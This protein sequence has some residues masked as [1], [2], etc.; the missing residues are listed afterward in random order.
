MWP[1]P[2][3]SAKKTLWLTVSSLLLFF[4]VLFIRVDFRLNVDVDVDTPF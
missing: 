4:Q 1:A 3:L 2:G